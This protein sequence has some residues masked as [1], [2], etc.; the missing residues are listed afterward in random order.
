MTGP[1]ARTGDHRMRPLPFAAGSLNGISE[2]MIVSH[3][4]NNYGGAARDQ[5]RTEQE[6][7]QIPRDTPPLLVAALR[8][9][10]LTFRNSKALHETYLAHLGGDGR[11]SGSVETAFGEAYGSSSRWADMYEHSYQ[12]DFGAP[13]PRY[14]DAFFANVGWDEVNAR[15]ERAQG[16]W[17][18][19]SRDVLE[20]ILY[21]RPQFAGCWRRSRAPRRP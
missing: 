10:E 8:E 13:V 2:R 15:F 3:H 11:R 12:M 5:N 7:A 17:A 14:L 6:L 9:R 20:V 21:T 4:E 16:V 1:A 18:T 19:A